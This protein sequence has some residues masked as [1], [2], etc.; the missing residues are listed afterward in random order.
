MKPRFLWL[1]LIFFGFAF[2]LPSLSAQNPIRIALITDNP[3]N[4]SLQFE[5][6]IVD[7]IE[8]LL[9]NKYAVDI[10]VRYA[11]QNVQTSQTFIQEVYA[12][13]TYDFLVGSGVMTCSQLVQKGTYPIPTIASI[14]IDQ[15]L[16]AVPLTEEGTSG[17]ENFTYI[18]SPFSLQRDLKALNDIR[19][20]EKV[21][22]LTSP[23]IQQGTT[24][25]DAIFAKILSGIEKEYEIIPVNNSVA[26]TLETL[27]EAIDAIYLLPLFNDFNDA[28]YKRLLDGLADKGL[29]VF[30]LISDPAVS[31]GAYAAYES[32]DNISKIP[33]RVAL[34]ISK[35]LEGQAA[36]ELPVTLTSF[37]DHLIIN[38]AAANKTKIY[39]GW[40]MLAQSILV[41]VNVVDT[42]RRLTLQAAI[43]EGLQQNLDL[44]IARKETAITQKDVS[45]AQSDLLPQVSG[46]SSGVILDPNTVDNS[47]GQAGTFTWSGGFS[48][49]QVLV[50]EP[51]L[52]NI[53]IQKMLAKSQQYS[54]DQTELDVVLSVAEAY[55][56]LLQANAFVEIQNQ[57]VLVTR[58]NLDI[59]R[60]KEQV[61]Y[62]G[63]TDVY[64]WQSQLALSNIELNQALAQQQQAHFNLNALLNRP[65]SEPFETV[66][67]QLSDS[68]LLITDERL[69][70]WI[71]TPGDVDRFADFLVQEAF[72]NLPELKQIALAI[73]A[74]DRLRKSQK[75]AFYL[76]TVGLSGS[77]DQ[78]ILREGVPDTEPISIPGVGEFSFGSGP[79]TNPTWNLAVGLE[80]PL[81]QGM[82]RQRQ[83]DQTRIALAQLEDQQQQLKQQLELRLRSGMETVGASFAQVQLSREAADAARKNF[84]IAQDNYQQGIIN[85]ITL[86]DAQNTFLQ[87]ELSAVTAV[88]QFMLDF[89]T[90]E[91]SVGRYYFLSTTEEKLDFYYRYLQFFQE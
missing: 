39:P 37:S 85:V 78:V 56:G 18:Q 13:D 68:M 83:L 5:D 32:S 11:A 29:P 82:K 26:S 19:S 7:E 84:D 42:D 70:N 79:I 3:E 64:R 73:A 27:P 6:L 57:N 25:F 59:S 21:G 2:H 4:D 81:F 22:I 88:Y 33:R 80:F 60:A 71:R 45:I 35:I 10:D 48:L 31:M 43:Y 55:L 34:N 61:G 86:I 46:T 47:F 53:A 66:E 62:G 50:S 58:T 87:T 23:F 91:R 52:A 74:Q 36:A 20:F 89:L 44:K 90:L 51:L 12:S 9:G 14:I 76:P 65:I 67:A 72:N 69:N 17:V 77:W 28:E 8:A 30:A 63:T 40:D 16:Q 24:N 38:M 75:R 15:E 1:I 54:Q 49:S 41:N